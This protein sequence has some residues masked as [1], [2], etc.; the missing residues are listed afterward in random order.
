MDFD[1]G[2]ASTIWLSWT[3]VMNVVGHLVTIGL[4][5]EIESPESMKDENLKPKAESLRKLTYVL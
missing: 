4:L 5:Y 2:S 1:L 3:V